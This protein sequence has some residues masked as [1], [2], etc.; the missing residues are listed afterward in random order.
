MSKYHSMGG[1]AQ[2]CKMFGQFIVTDSNGNT[3]VWVYDYDLD[4]PVRKSEMTVEQYH[5]SM[6]AKR[7]KKP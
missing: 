7:K 5:R 3:V 4:K 1:L 6:E 2:I